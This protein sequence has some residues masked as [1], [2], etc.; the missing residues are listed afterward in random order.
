MFFVCF[1]LFRTAKW[2]GLHTKAARTVPLWQITPHYAARVQEAGNISNRVTKSGLALLSS[3]F[4]AQKNLSVL[5][6]HPNTGTQHQAHGTFNR[7]R[8]PPANNL[9]YKR[10]RK[11]GCRVLEAFM[12]KR[13]LS[14]APGGASGTSLEVLRGYPQLVPCTHGCCRSWAGF[15]VG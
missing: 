3:T 4:V 12:S 14:A 7:V 1:F 13:E 2:R 15:A 6:I 5:T 9:A 10:G 8:G 11:K